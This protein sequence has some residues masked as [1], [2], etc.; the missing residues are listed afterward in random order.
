MVVVG[1]VQRCSLKEME[2]GSGSADGGVARGEQRGGNS[3]GVVMPRECGRS[4][5]DA[6]CGVGD[7]GLLRSCFGGA[8]KR[9]QLRACSALLVTA[10]HQPARGL[11]LPQAARRLEEMAGRRLALRRHHTTSIPAITIGTTH[12]H[13]NTGLY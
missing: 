3:W 13:G 10:K 5:G 7:G 9:S 11:C 8:A 2:C 12:A 4:M 6:S 1:E